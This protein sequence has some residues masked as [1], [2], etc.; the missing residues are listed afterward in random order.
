MV[1]EPQVKA[2]ATGDLVPVRDDR[3]AS[4]AF[5]RFTESHLDESYRLAWAIL[6]DPT[7]AEDAV[8]DALAHAWR[9][10]VSLRD[11][12]RFE[13]WFAR[14]LV[15]TCRN[16]L[17]SQSRSRLTDLSPQ[18]DRP[19]PR[20]PFAPIHDRDEIGRA[21]AA[22]D[23]DHRVVI[24][25]R[26]HADLSIDQIG[27]HLGLPSGTVKSRLHHALRRLQAILDEGARRGVVR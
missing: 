17:R 9:G 22:L 6:G 1:D 15:N 25:L 14:I 10:S 3:P 12:S 7:E 5:R 20:D 8:Q 18:L 26:F 24:A 13:A 2:V 11:V 4:E 21:L 16:R 23:P 27:G 19:Q